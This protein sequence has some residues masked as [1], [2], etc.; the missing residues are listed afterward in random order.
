[1]KKIALFDIDKTLI[2]Y[3]SFLKWITLILKRKKSGFW[4]LPGLLLSGITAFSTPQKLTRYKE[5]WL[6][7]ADGLTK[8]EIAELSERFVKECIIPDLKP[9]VEEKIKQYKDS[10]YTIIFATASF[11]VYFRY[12]AEYFN[13]DYFFG[14]QVQNYDGK[15]R[16]NGENC[17]GQEKIRRILE[18]LPENEIDKAESVGFSDSMS[19]YPFSRLVKSFYLVDK[20][21]WKTLKSFIN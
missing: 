16:I 15:W 17:K 7:L 5:K 12:L 1:M 10:G 2:P 11:E 14:T 13:V 19:D 18:K 20:K 6:S 21:R 4:R 8:D 9:G 3:D